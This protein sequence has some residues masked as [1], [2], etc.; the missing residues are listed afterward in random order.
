MVDMILLKTHKTDPD[1]GV[2]LAMCDKNLEGQTLKEGKVHMDLGPKYI[3]FYKG[4]CVRKE[5]A[6]E[7]AS[8][9]RIASANAVGIESVDVLVK[10]NLAPFYAVQRAKDENGVDVPFVHVYPTY[11]L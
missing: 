11:L 6:I 1:H 4:Q 3:G 9:V 8:K 5:K 7:I 2:I 10:N